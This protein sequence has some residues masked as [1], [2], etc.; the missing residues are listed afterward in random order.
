MSI[1]I[2]FE[3]SSKLQKQLL[4]LVK[5]KLL[6]GS[7]MTMTLRTKSFD[8]VYFIELSEKGVTKLKFQTE[9][10]YGIF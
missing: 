9:V 3:V 2:V 4:K 5:V 10:I 6:F 1:L 8:K 7:F